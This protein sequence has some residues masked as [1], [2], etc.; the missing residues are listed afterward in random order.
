MTNQDIIWEQRIQLAQE[1]RLGYT[2]RTL[3]I[4]TTEGEKVF[5]EPQEIHT[6]ATWKKLGFRVK[7]GEHHIAKFPIWKYAERTRVDEETQEEH[8]E[9]KMFLKVSFFF[10]PAQVEK[11][12]GAS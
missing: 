9:G 11:I 6:Y 8:Q 12:G 4:Q 5:Q 10:S 2:G 1:G 3:T 7:R